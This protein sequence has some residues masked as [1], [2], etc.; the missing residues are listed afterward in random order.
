MRAYVIKSG[1]IVVA[2][3]EATDDD[4]SAGFP[5]GFEWVAAPHVWAPAAGPT[6]DLSLTVDAPVA[7]VGQVINVT[8]ELT[9]GG[10]P[11]PINQIFAVP[12]ESDSGQVVM[13]KAVTFVGG[14]ASLTLTFARSGYYRITEKAINSRLAGMFIRFPVPLEVVVFE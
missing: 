8:A 7:G 12:I 13:V 5:A 6:I 3:G 9:V 1:G 10:M 2:S 14:H 4:F 11:A